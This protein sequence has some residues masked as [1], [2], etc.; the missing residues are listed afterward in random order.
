M[1]DSRIAAGRSQFTGIFILSFAVLAYQVLLT[2]IFSV[3]LHYHF[4]FAGI[5][6]AMLGMTFGANRVF[7]DN[8]K[9]YTEY[10][11]QEWAKS[12]LGFAASSV[13]LILWFLYVPAMLPDPYYGQLLAAISMMLF[14]IPFFYSGICVTLILTKSAFPVGRLYAADLVGAALGCIGIVGILFFLD[15]ITIL[16]ALATFSAFAAWDM[17]RSSHCAVTRHAKIAT[18]LFI[19]LSVTQGSL[20]LNGKPHLG[21]IWA[22]GHKQEGVEFE[23]WNSFSHVAIL[24][25]QE[26]YPFGWAFGRPVTGRIAQYFLQIDADAGSVVT[27]FDGDTRP[28]SFLADDLINIGYHIRKPKTV[29]V[30]GVGGGRDIMSGLYFGAQKITAIE[31]NPAIIEAL[32]RQFADFIGNFYKR[33]D[34]KLVNSEARS[35][36]NN[37]GGQYDLIQISLIDTWAATAAGGLTLSESKLY[38]VD[39]WDDFLKRLTSDGMIAVSRWYDPV[40]HKG[41]FYRLLA[42]ATD[43]LENVGVKAK[44]IKLHILVFQVDKIVTVVTSKSPFK[45]EEIQHIR[46]EA[47]RRG[48]TVM[49]APDAPFDMISSTIL[50]GDAD[51]RFYASLPID[52][53]PSTDD[54]PFFFYHTRMRDMLAGTGQHD[55]GGNRGEKGIGI[56]LL[57]LTGTLLCYIYFTGV[58]VWQL[59]K[60]PK[61]RGAASYLLYFSGIGVGFM[62]VEISQMQRLMIFLGHPVYGLSVVLFTL[63]L[64]G[65]AGSFCVGAIRS[66]GLLH[67]LPVL[68]LATLVGTGYFTPDITA[69]LKSFGVEARIVC[70]VLMVAPVGFFMGMMFPIGMA[71]VRNYRMLQPSLWAINGSSSVF[72]SVLGVA[73][74]M[75]YGISVTY[76]CGVAC[77]LLC[78]L[79]VLSSNEAKNA[80]TEGVSIQPDL[81]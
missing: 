18:L 10:F 4:A 61:L 50:S 27:H 16:F 55:E 11:A 54:R 14:A 68:L 37:N 67:L 22:K 19:A 75:A 70:S 43:S 78:T 17:A 36:L 28:L 44:D 59:I 60:E 31:I 52:V 33:N 62:L 5:A 53:S 56:V 69:S 57:M 24:D 80:S 38:T 15:P 25:Y 79:I 63:L 29:A 34:V 74:S 41:E 64:S 3:V 6:L 23:R 30:I 58:S 49:V 2:R 72:A 20:Y 45:T 48:F 51:A 32:T 81:V 26:T 66:T 13:A 42:I 12:A 40:L 47:Q 8:G 77:Y 39:A 65:G 46:R 76:W 71:H 35:W 1:N 7:L 9:R 21:L 73:V